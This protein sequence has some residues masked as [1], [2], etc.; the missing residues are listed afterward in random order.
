MNR[1]SRLA[2]SLKRPA[3]KIVEQTLR[4]YVEELV[5]RVAAPLPSQSTG[6]SAPEFSLHDALHMARS[7]ALCDMP[8]GAK[9][10]LSAGPNGAWYFDW[11][12]DSYGKVERH[13][14]VEA[15]TSRPAELPE[16]V[17]WI[18]A[19]IAS[20][21][22]VPSIRDG[23]IN[24]VFSGQNIEHLWPNQVVNFL[25]EANRVL[26]PH[27][28]LV[29]DS[30]NRRLTSAYRWSMSEH[31][32]EFTPEEAV[33]LLELGGFEVKTMK[34]LWLCRR[35]GKLFGLD[36]EPSVMSKQ[37]LERIVLSSTRPDDSFIWWAE[38]IKVGAPDPASLKE[39]VTRIYTANWQE[40]T[41]RLQPHGTA[42][43][44]VP[45]ESIVLPKGPSG[46]FPLGPYMPLPPARYRFELEVRWHHCETTED[47]LGRFEVVAGDLLVGSSELRPDT[48][49]DGSTTA[50]CDVELRQLAFATHVRLYTT[51]LA[52]LEVPL[53]LSIDPAPWRVGERI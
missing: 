5:E 2:N 37:N 45:G 3:R 13:I 9:I 39:E 7:L 18:E 25:M 23:E 51:G 8:P 1:N 27:G 53:A 52:R 48:R 11:I 46:Y 19:D 50:V 35:M 33:R 44:D 49:P 32:L 12:E 24:L 17:D 43:M 6:P 30:P 36:P 29:L 14:G 28:W 38:A 47:P 10:M 15:Y 16:Y 4:P 31:T 20:S 26:S 40:R 41:S 34:G 22:G 42:V 21:T